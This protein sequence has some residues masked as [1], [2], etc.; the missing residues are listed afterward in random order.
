[1]PCQCNVRSE[2]W[3]SDI[4]DTYNNIFWSVT[5]ICNIFLCP[6]TSQATSILKVVQY[7]IYVRFIIYR[8]QYLPLLAKLIIGRNFIFRSQKAFHGHQ[9][10]DQPFWRLNVCDGSNII[11]RIIAKISFDHHAGVSRLI[12]MRQE[13]PCLKRYT[14]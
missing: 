8:Q 12:Q 10:V 7:K 4:D 3:S 1:M 5:N 9:R 11:K 2:I 13:V 6:F 14:L